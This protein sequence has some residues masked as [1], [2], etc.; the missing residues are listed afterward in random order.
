MSDEPEF[1]FEVSYA[2]IA[3]AIDRKDYGWL[4]EHVFTPAL[5]QF[6]RKK[7]TEALINNP[8]TRARRQAGTRRHGRHP[9]RRISQVPG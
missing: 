2:D 5:A 9:T 8:R 3:A 6:L 7:N 4:C 1:H